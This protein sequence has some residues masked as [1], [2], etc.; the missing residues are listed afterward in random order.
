MHDHEGGSDAHRQSDLLVLTEGRYH[1]GRLCKQLVCGDVADAGQQT[2]R[3]GRS[4]QGEAEGDREREREVSIQFI[5]SQGYSLECVL[6]I[7]ERE[8]ATEEEESLL[9][10][11]RSQ[12]LS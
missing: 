3:G 5:N 11:S 10:E 8:G 9:V 1:R 12:Q 6:I 4:R 2:D 7:S